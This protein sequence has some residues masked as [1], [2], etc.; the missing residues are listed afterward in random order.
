MYGSIL[1]LKP[2]SLVSSKVLKGYNV[3]ITG[4]FSS[5]VF[6]GMKTD[7]LALER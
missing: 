7:T 2:S 6:K 5:S 1:N 3:E 4:L